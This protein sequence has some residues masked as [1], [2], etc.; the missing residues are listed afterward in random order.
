M[1]LEKTQI[2][3]SNDDG[4]HSKGIWAAAESLAGLGYITVAAPSEPM[5][6]AGRGF[7]RN[8]DGRITTQTMRV[9]SQDWEVHA[10]GGSPSQSVAHAILEIMPKKPALV[11]SGI[12]YGEN[13]AT[14]ITYS[15]TVGAA[16]EGA[17]LGIPAMAVSQ[18]IFH[19]EYTEEN[20]TV[21][22]SAA[23]YFT[24]YFAS[25]LLK[26]KLP[27]DVDVL[28]VVIPQGAT[29]E[30][31]W[32]VTHLLRSRYY[33]PTITRK[34]DWEGFA[35]FTSHIIPP[36][37]MVP[38]DDDVYTVRVKHMVSVTPLSIDLTSRVDLKDLERLLRE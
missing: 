24:Q 23:A 18:Q 10:V 29:P 7:A 37:D 32:M 4:I 12:N 5:S 22:F 2:L 16:L 31:P 11:V 25:L 36:E 13:F 17:S 30:T 14:D 33:K 38:A 9:N 8:A 1:N 19:D 34:G 6:G 35:K 21:D 26:K 3:L 20:D 28:N 15:G 27:F